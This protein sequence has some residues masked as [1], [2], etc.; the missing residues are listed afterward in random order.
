MCAEV[1]ELTFAVIVY[2]RSVIPLSTLFTE[3]APR[4]SE[5]VVTLT[6]DRVTQVSVRSVAVAVTWPTGAARRHRVAIVTRIAAGM[7]W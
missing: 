5:A 1:I 6:S 7:E 4:L 3:S 2:R